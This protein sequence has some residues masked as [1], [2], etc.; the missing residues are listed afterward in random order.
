MLVGR[1]SFRRRPLERGTPDARGA[2]GGRSARPH[3]A[4]A[5]W[6]R[7]VEAA[8][9]LC[10]REVLRR[11]RQPSHARPRSLASAPPLDRGRAFL[12][13]VSACPRR[14]SRDREAARRE[15]ARVAHRRRG[16]RP[17]PVRDPV[18]RDRVRAV[19]LLLG[20]L[21]SFS[22]LLSGFLVVNTIS[23]I[24]AQQV[25]EIGVMKAIG[26]R[27]S[28]RCIWPRPWPMR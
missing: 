25:R 11:P 15:G 27:R 4:R 9:A 7:R 17:Q 10:H 23:S 26:A 28:W 20:V 21:E 24:M 3:R 16:P 14:R 2:R 12:R 8:A 19:T 18:H 22:L 6:L 5:G 1:R 13:A